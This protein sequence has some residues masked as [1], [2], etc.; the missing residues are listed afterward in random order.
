MDGGIRTRPRRAP[1]IAAAGLVAALVLPAASPGAGLFRKKSPYRKGQVVAF[2]GQVADSTGRALGGATVM[3]EVSRT[4]F[5]LESLSRETSNTL[6]MPVAADGGGN[7]RIDW[8]WDRFY[9]TFA[10]V[11]ALRVRENGAD[12]YEVFHRLEI[13]DRVAGGNPVETPLVLADAAAYDEL[14]AFLDSV[15]SD[16]AKRVYREMGRPD[17]IDT[18]E[19]D[20]DPDHSWW[21]FEAGKVYRFRDGKLD[22]VVPFEPIAEE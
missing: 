20:Y 21:Y 16:D 17:R 1:R 11:V 3:L 14:R 5:R 15:E 18:G 2:T 4:S 12:T 10:L 8:R 13:T 7:Y 9:N 19:A 22:Q 6:Q